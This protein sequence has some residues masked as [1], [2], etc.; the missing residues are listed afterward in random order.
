MIDNTNEN[1]NLTAEGSAENTE[2]I[3][4]PNEAADPRD[5]TKEASAEVCQSKKDDPG[6]K[7]KR[8]LGEVVECLE[9]AVCAIVAVVLIF[10]AGFRICF[11]NG[12]SMNKTL[13]HQDWVLVSD[14]GYEPKCGDIIVFHM[15]SDKYARLN[16][17][18]VKRVIAVS[19]QWI[20][21]DFDTWTLRIADNPNMEN[22]TVVDEPYR[23]LDETKQTLKSTHTFPLE[24]PEGYIFVMGD[25]RNNSLDSRNAEQIGLVDTRR[26]LGKVILRVYPFKPIKS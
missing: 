10:S 1:E 15:T 3:D 11:V 9:I 19:G 23:Y 16:E 4:M 18:M 14:I 12:T 21:I 24:I 6:S 26:V 7:I 17:P 20:D 2:S 8:T 13:D 25:N 22:A 5:E